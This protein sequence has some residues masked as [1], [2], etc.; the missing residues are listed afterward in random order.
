MA[1]IKYKDTNGNW[2][3]AA[4][5]NATGIATSN[6]K[7]TGDLDKTSVDNVLE[8][9][10]DRVAKL[11]RNVAWLAKHGG[12][13]SGG[14]SGS[15]ISE[16]TCNIY[17]N[18]L[19]TDNQVILDENGLT[20]ELRDISVKATKAWKV[21]IRIGSVQV[22]SS[23]AS[24][25]APTMFIPFNTISS[26]LTNHTG[27]LYIS[28][29]YD[30]EM[31]SVFGSASWSG[32]IVESVVK[33][34]T[35]DLS[36]NLTDGGEL[37]TDSSVIYTYSVGI[38]ETYNL[39][40]IVYK[41]GEEINTIN[42]EVSPIDTG[43]HTFS[44]N[45]SELIPE[46]NIGVYNIVSQLYNTNNVQ[47]QNTIRTSITLVSK[48]ILI[49]TNIMSEDV[50]EPIDVNLSGSINFVWTAYLQGSITFQYNYKIGNTI[51][52]DNS[53]GYFG[54][55]INDFVSVINKDWAVEGEVVPITLTITVGNET[56]TKIWY[57]RFIQSDDSF[58]SKS[59][60]V[61][62]HLLSEFLSRNY[63][64]GDQNFNLINNDYIANS[65]YAPITSNLQLFDVS[66]LVGVKTSLNK[67]PYLRLSN[68]SYGILKDFNVD[69][70]PKTFPSIVNAVNNDFT[71]SICFKADYH[72]DDNRTILC[73][74]QLD[75]ISGQLIT[76]VEIGVHD[77][78]VNTS[79]LWR[80]SDNTVNNI[81]IVCIHTDDDYIDSE[82]NK[83]QER[84][85]I[86][87]IYIEG[88]CSATAN[89]STFPNLGDNIYIG[90]KVY[91]DSDEVGWLCDCDIYNL[92]VY[93]Y[94][95]SELDIELNRINNKVSTNY[96]NNNF[97]FSLI[98]SELR[99]NFCERDANNEIISHLYKNGAYTIDFL[100]EGNRLSEEKL[101]QYAKVVGIPIMLIDVSNDDNWTFE[102]F[103]NQQSADNVQLKPTSGKTIYYWDPTQEN[104]F[105]ITINGV[106]IELQGT[107]TLADAVKNVNITLPDNTVFV[108]KQTW[109]P[110]KTYTLKADVVDSSHSCNGSI[111]GFINTI[112]KD[113]LPSD[114]VALDNVENSDYVKNQQPTATLKHTV[115]GFPILLIMNFHTTETSKVS[116][117]ALGIYSFNLG[118]DA[119]RN[120]GFKKVNSIT[121]SLGELI[122]VNTFP[123]VSEYCNINEIDA[124]AHWIEIK[125]T[126][127]IPDMNKIEGSSLPA[128][129]DSSIGDFWQN[130]ASIV[131]QR[132]EVRY[133]A[134]RKASDYTSFIRFI[135]FIMQLPVEGLH[136]TTDRI[137]N[138]V[139][140]E[141]T[142]P[143]DLYTYNNGYIK[144]GR[145]Q[146][147]ITDVNAMADPN[148]NATSIY[149]YFV[150]ANFF[151]LIDNFGKNAVFKSYNGGNYLMGF[152]DLDCGV[153][154]GNQG[155]LSI[156]PNV[157]LKYLKNQILEGKNYGFVGETFNSDDP[158][159]LS[160]TVFS[161]NHNKIWLSMDTPTARS[162][163]DVASF[164]GTSAYAYYWDDLRKTIY[165]AAI[166]AGY[167]DIAEYFVNEFFL[168]QTGNC[169]SLLFNLDYKLKYFVQ[170]TDDKYTNTKHLS[171]LHG[172]KEAY[173][174]DWLKRH[175]LF[176]DSVFYWRNV[177]QGFAYP[178][179]VNSKMSSTVYNTPEYIPIVSN[180]D[181]IVY[182]NVGNATQTYYYLPKNQ[183]VYVDAGNNNSNSEVTWGITNSPQIIKLGDEEVPLSKM[184]IYR[185][186]HTNTELHINN[187]GLGAITELELQDSES[188]A[189]PFALDSFKPEVGVSELRSID[190]ANTLSRLVQGSRPTFTLELVTQLAG[191]AT[192]T[193]FTKLRE[194]DI[195]NS[196]CVSDITIPSVPLKRL[197][198]YNSALTNLNL[199]NQNYIRSIDL[200][201]CTKLI[202]I[203]I[204]E[205]AM[206]ET[207]NISNL[208]N[209]T[210]VN[211]V[212]NV[213]I[214]S[215]VINNCP[216]LQKVTIQ[217]N[218][219]LT[220]ISITNCNKL[221]GNTASNYLT[222][223]DNVNLTSL[224]LSNCVNLVT[225][226]I[227]NSNQANISTLDLTNDPITYISGD[228]ADTSLLD[229]SKFTYGSG[230]TL[231][232]NKEV[233]EIQFLNNINNPIRIS[234]SFQN[235]I[236]L[237]RIYGNI[238]IAGNSGPNG[239]GMFL[240]CSNFS[241]HGD[242]DDGL[243][244][245]VNTWNGK[246]TRT[247]T[248]VKTIYECITDDSNN[249]IVNDVRP[250]ST[251][252]WEQ[253]FVSGNK[254]TNI[255][256]STTNLTQM[257]YGTH[258]TEFD[259]M[260]MMFVIGKSLSSSYSLSRT[261]YNLY[262]EENE[263]L[264]F[265]LS[266]NRYGVPRFL[267]YNFTNCTDLSEVFSTA[268]TIVRSKTNDYIEDGGVQDTNSVLG[269]LTNCKTISRL[270][271]TIIVDNNLFKIN[272]GNLKLT[273]FT[274]QSVE[275][276][277]PGNSD[278]EENDW[279]DNNNYENYCTSRYTETGNFEDM[280]VV[281]PDLTRLYSTFNC[282][283]I[284]FD[285]ITLPSK[286]T[287]VSLAFNAQV[288]GKGIIDFNE[289]FAL[290]S[291][292]SI[293]TY[294][295]CT[296]TNSLY[297]SQ[298][299]FP[300]TVNM[301]NNYTKLTKI[302]YNP[303]DTNQNDGTYAFAGTRKY[304][305]DNSFPENIVK[306][307]T[308]LVVFSH[309]FYDCEDKTFAS[310][311][312]FPGN[313]FTTNT[314]LQNIN[315]ILRNAH[316]AY[317]LSPNGF[318]NCPSLNNVGRAFQCNPEETKANRS[319]L[320][321]EIP[322]RLFYH[323]ETIS[324]ITKYGTN[325]TDEPDE[326][327]DIENDLQ[328]TVIQVTTPRIGITDMK[329]C[330]A[331]CLN[332]SYYENVDNVNGIENNPDYSPYKWN[333][334][335]NSKTWSENTELSEKIAY[336]TYTGVPNSKNV[337]YK[338][339]ED[340]VEL[341]I[342]NT[343]PDKFETLNYMCAPDLLRYANVNCNVEGL[344]DYCGLDFKVYGI[345]NS[346]EDYQSL[347]ITGRIPPYLFKPVPNITNINYIFRY[348][349]KLSSYK[350]E[351]VIYQI[352]KDLF[353]YATNITT[354]VSAFQGLDFINGT[355]LA[356]FNSLKNS[357]DVRKIFCF[358]RYFK[359]SSNVAHSVSNV[360]ANNR[361]VKITGA[362]AENDISLNGDFDASERT[363]WDLNNGDN[364]SFTNNFATNKVP[365]TQNIKWVYYGW[366]SNATDN[367][368][369][370]GNNNY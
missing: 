255:K 121:D 323:G 176:L 126:T 78:F 279:L 222:I 117:T 324:N 63:N 175:I 291:D 83:K 194:I 124:N 254:V 218:A 315:S 43:E 72:P 231:T 61:K 76:G 290:C 280:F 178:N 23:S 281:L 245:G 240:N 359:N 283:T 154:G 228:N 269:F 32:S 196:Q 103:V 16:A 325:Q 248:G 184:N 107:S 98:D 28:A 180:T 329:Y 233:E 54:T 80:L 125:D 149:K 322:A 99:Y 238:I 299:E 48:Q 195:S 198:V 95:L 53:I 26:A 39:R 52:K 87:K 170:F 217:N 309:F 29:S 12:G 274:H 258:L 268:K 79:S 319:K 137:G 313:M 66:N 340:D 150:V 186:S 96:K 187:P 119:F 37:E 219:N 153:G 164:T 138:I 133:P 40:I 5:G 318:A 82:G 200:S 13:G 211:I 297:G 131:D 358:C 259:V 97:D 163:F 105:V 85:Y 284:N 306:N 362:F 257:F 330:F 311:P 155:I 223:T 355:Q 210:E 314:K 286:I 69:G 56:A 251:V 44:I 204:K 156:E 298:A 34:H 143:Y 273:S 249:Y 21:L 159:R 308:N 336:W 182:H 8:N 42:N 256:L 91:G 212:N 335:N 360:F 337:N 20:I 108:P 185:L 132:Y 215:I 6:P 4:S 190:F 250:Y 140:P 320:T 285:T 214:S 237:K 343:V 88:K 260:Y 363:Y 242:S 220:N 100:L 366:G 272:Y 71:I 230:I 147:I 84:H 30:D 51:I 292:L 270:F 73:C 148:F 191:G 289:I 49:S 111:G 109:L 221:I 14:G 369:P 19:E 129:F 70:T 364:A 139:R 104:T 304:I 25:S 276:V 265:D 205:C 93:D 321:G 354:L 9:H 60:V 264:L 18:G 106:S 288:A 161:A 158:L 207:L 47:I 271:G 64:N 209:L 368:I 41:D 347:G 199:D 216:N 172:R 183:V 55:E 166:V 333:Y 135:E 275:N 331:G 267:F 243:C 17:V 365:N 10:E 62:S 361:I 57:F 287:E 293:V 89:Y 334:N 225:F 189:A 116:T 157:W 203:T 202:K 188:L 301:F 356:I 27:N 305:A 353:K 197:A 162:K 310:T 344:F 345:I 171:K 263:L 160:N 102:N 22:A 144:T 224:S 120:L 68:G 234:S 317:S 123:F 152:Y 35:S 328:S 246:A 50:S 244:L 239:N 227:S 201:G 349:R 38:L 241:I 165:N 253:S 86:I 300:I 36:V 296:K 367:I 127:S 101:N 33:L 213:A 134:N 312:K 341:I 206:Y 303:D 282:A 326:N 81:D 252:T 262:R 350:S 226:T 65:R 181:L 151:G 77:I 58:I 130:D 115:E 236:K 357:I 15:G 2:R 11:E 177:S 351:G 67:P 112:L 346:D 173:T 339:L 352:P 46:L 24:Y 278:F 193:K 7:L 118:R 327:F 142:T 74:G 338:Y 348:C 114:P 229:L 235:C 1:N 45:V 3:V 208:N 232:G 277:V 136:T 113:Y 294:A 94:A 141:I 302:G 145:Q 92:Q 266:V 167:N 332:L 122:T 316:F 168:K 146:Q 90:G 110:E 169:G 75:S 192:D 370:S 59:A 128:N 295:F 31:N 342:D 261:F 307:N 247:N 174:L 179:D